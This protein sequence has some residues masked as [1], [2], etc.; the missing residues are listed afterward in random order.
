MR[1]PRGVSEPLLLSVG[2]WAPYMFGHWIVVYTQDLASQYWWLSYPGFLF[3]PLPILLVMCLKNVR[4]PRWNL[5]WPVAGASAASVACLSIVMSYQTV[6]ISLLC[7]CL[8]VAGFGQIYLFLRWW[9]KFKER[10][11][12]TVLAAFLIGV[13]ATSLLK[14]L[15]PVLVDGY[16]ALVVLLPFLSILALQ[17]LPQNAVPL[18]REHLSSKTLLSFWRLGV[19]ITV[20]LF[21][22]GF[23]DAAVAANAGHYGFSNGLSLIAQG[24]DIGFAGS[25]L[26]YVFVRKGVIEYLQLWSYMYVCLAF[27]L[28][29]I[30]FFGMSQFV[31]IFTGASFEIAHMLI[32]I[33]TVDLTQRTSLPKY[34]L[35]V[36]A[37]MVY[38]IADW[39]MGSLVSVESISNLGS[40]TIAVLFFLAIAMLAFFLPRR[41]TAHQCILLDLN[42]YI[43]QQDEYGEIEMRCKSL[44]QA[45]GLSER[46]LEIM[47]YLCQGRSKPYIAETLYLSENTVKSYTKNLYKKLGIHSKQ[48]LISLVLPNAE[49]KT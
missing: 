41:T 11:L 4:A 28:V 12:G 46:E 26:W 2:F 10:P 31:Q 48:D 40:E 23:L 29:M 34:V 20:F 24:I 22:W 30:V 9:G 19:A 43:P 8:V 7:L 21:M 42:R 3:L 44:A 37:E 18:V 15:M 35:F 45:Y 32:L 33:A 49:S 5:D 13:I 47:Q 14:A 27:A 36:L 17:K 39:S 1:L 25:M 38:T 6:S 16:V